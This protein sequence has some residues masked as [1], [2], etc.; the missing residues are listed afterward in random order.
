V[1][2]LAQTNFAQSGDR[3][4]NAKAAQEHMFSTM[5]T[6]QWEQTNEKIVM[7][8]EQFPEEKYD[9][10]PADGTRTFGG[11]LRHLAFWNQFVANSA[12]GIKTDETLNELPIRECPTKVQVVDALKRSTEEATAALKAHSAEMELKTAELCMT[13]TQHS[14]EHYG[15]L[16]VYY[17]LNGMVPPASRAEGQ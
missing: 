8:A 6:K 9:F 13:F 1:P 16:V 10:S 5:L 14:S 12:R 11:V 7:L 4:V 2:S 3:K 15:Q 17:R